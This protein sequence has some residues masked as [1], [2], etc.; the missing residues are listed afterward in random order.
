MQQELHH[1]QRIKPSSHIVENNSRSPGQFFQLP[2]RWR[3]HNIEAPEEYKARQQRFPCDRGKQK[4][5][6]LSGNLVDYQDW[7]SGAQDHI[8]P[9]LAHTIQGSQPG[10]LLFDGERA[11]VGLLDRMTGC[12]RHQRPTGQSPVN[13][14]TAPSPEK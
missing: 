3:L 5:D 1:C 4:R 10:E 12:L 9:A 7:A 2:H 14:E 11:D 6:P 13:Y 8:D